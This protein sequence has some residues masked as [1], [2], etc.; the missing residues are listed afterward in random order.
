MVRNE[1]D[2]ML[3]LIFRVCCSI[4]TAGWCETLVLASLLLLCGDNEKVL[5]SN[6]GGV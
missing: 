1:D 4:T 5:K 3:V 6:E 2:A